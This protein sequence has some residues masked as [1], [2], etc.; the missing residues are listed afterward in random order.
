MQTEELELDEE[1][2][3]EVSHWPNIV[4]ALLDRFVLICA[5][6][7]IYYFFFCY[8]SFVFALYRSHCDS[9]VDEPTFFHSN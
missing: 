1:L 6:I 3:E 2:S 8:L 9:R 4:V 5:I 7:S